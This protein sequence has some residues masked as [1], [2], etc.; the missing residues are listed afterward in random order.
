MGLFQ[1]LV[2]LA[3][4]FCNGVAAQSFASVLT[5]APQCAADCLVTLFSEEPFAGKNQSAICHDQQFADAIG[6]CLTAKCT[7]RQTLDFIKMSSAVCGIKPTNNVLLYRL[8]TLI[9]AGLALLFFALRI[10]ATVRLRLKWAM[11]D[12]MAV[13]SVV[14]LIPVVIIMQFM[15]QNG[16]GVDLW[17]LSDHQI[18]EGF[19]LFF[20]LEM[21]YLTARV[22]VKSTILCFFLRIFSNPRFRLIVKITLVFNVLIGV[23]FFILVFFQT[24]PISLFWIGWQTKEAKRVMLGIIRLTLPHAV[25]VLALDIWVLILPITQLWELG[26]K[27]RKKIG[28]MAMFS[29][30]IFLTVVAVIRVH[31]LVLFARSRDL[32]GKFTKH[33]KDDP[34]NRTVIN[35]QK[36]MIWS[37]I[38]ISVGIMVSCMPH[39]RN[40]VRHIKSRI[41]EKRGKEKEPSNEAVFIQ[42]S[43]VPISVGDATSEPALFDEGD[44][45]TTVSTTT[46]TGKMESINGRLS[47]Y[48]SD[49]DTQV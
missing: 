10:I 17:Y 49:A 9:M 45:I 5:E 20:F 35:A 38:E 23:T 14:L 28:V 6:D 44:A 4:L 7:V 36:A 8:T 34:T 26:L 43:L 25:L 42:R 48:A 16:L 31:Q 39:I 30:G 32:T 29:F 18:T 11:D 41:R 15:M 47:S 1:H 40:L 22:V 27:L 3:A 21:L 33:P 37:C 46:G 13:A 24:T 12:T 19:R 2:F